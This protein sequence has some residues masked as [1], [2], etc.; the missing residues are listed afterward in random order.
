MAEGKLANDGKPESKPS[1]RAINGLFALYEGLTQYGQESRLDPLPVVCNAHLRPV[2]SGRDTDPYVVSAVLDRVLDKITDHLL[3][4]RGVRIHPD[5]LAARLDRH[6]PAGIVERVE[7]DLAHQRKQI[8]RLAAKLQLPMRYAGEIQQVVD[9]PAQ[10]M[11]LPIDDV[12]RGTG[13]LIM[14]SQSFED[15]ATQGNGCE[16]AAQL[17]RQ[18]GD[19]V[20][21]RA[22]LLLGIHAQA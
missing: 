12:H 6:G 8:E 20:V 10:L 22:V 16:G 18:N 3:D 11:N 2:A 21:L 7:I 5:R 1:L 9:E 19:K 14:P 17:M 13:Q 4:P 15:F